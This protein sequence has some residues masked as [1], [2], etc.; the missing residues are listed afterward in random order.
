MLDIFGRSGTSGQ[1]ALAD[2]YESVIRE[3][4]STS[5]SRVVLAKIESG[6][7]GVGEAAPQHP[8]QL[9]K[10]KHV[11]GEGYEYRVVIDALDR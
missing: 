11:N 3:A 2:A 9:T 8:V 5:P 1:R 10:T 6:T 4:Y 7:P